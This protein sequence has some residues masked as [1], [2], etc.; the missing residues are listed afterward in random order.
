MRAEI[1]R[2]HKTTGASIVYFTHDQIEAMTLATR[3]VVLKGGIV[4]QIG[5]PHEIYDRPTNTFVADFMGTPP[6]NLMP[7]TVTKKGLLLGDQ[8]VDMG[9][10]WGDRKLPEQVIAGIRPEHVFVASD[11]ADLRLRPEMVE[12]TGAESFVLFRLAGKPFLA[13]LPGR[14][15][16]DAPGELELEIDRAAVNLF[17]AT[18]GMRIDS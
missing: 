7:A 3:I 13:K 5:T 12:H 16:E 10:G 8:E 6:M 9:K 15:D 4:Q 14:F 18:T 2:L 1:K 11:K 17:D